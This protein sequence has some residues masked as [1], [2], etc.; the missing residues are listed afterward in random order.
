MVSYIGNDHSSYPYSAVTYIEST[1]P[2]GHTYS[3]TG[4][5]VGENDVL[6][7]SHII[8]SL[9]DGGVAE[10]VDVYPG[11]DRSQAPFGSYDADYVNYF[12]VDQDGDGLMTRSDSEDDLAVLGFD[13]EIVEQTGKFNLDPNGTSD[14]YNITG[15]PAQYADETGPRMTNDYGYIS[16]N[17]YFDV[18]DISE[19][20]VSPGN[21]GSPLWYSSNSDPFVVGVNSTRGWS[22]DIASHYSKIKG[23]MEN[24][25]SLLKSESKG[26]GMIRD[27]IGLY[28]SNSSKFYLQN[29]LTGGKADTTVS[30]GPDNQN[31]KPLSSELGVGLYS[32]DNGTFYLNNDKR[33]GNADQTIGFGPNNNDW[34][35]LADDFNGDN[36]TDLGL[37]SPDRGKFYFDYDQNGGKA[38]DTVGFGPGGENWLPITGDFNGDGKAG[39]GLYN[40]NNGTFYLDN[41]KRG[42]NADHTFG[43]GP[44]GNNW[45]PVAGNWD[46]DE[47]DEI[48]LYNP[49]NA[50]F[51]LDYDNKGGNADKTI[52]FGPDNNNWEPVINQFSED[53]DHPSINVSD[54]TVTEGD[55]GTT[56]AEFTVSL[57]QPAQNEV[58][59]D[60]A[61]SDDTAT[62]GDDYESTSGSL[63]FSPSETEKTV[64][65]DVYGD[66]QV[67]GDETFSLDLSSPT[68]AEL[69]T[70]AATG[71][72][73]DEDTTD[74]N[75]TIDNFAGE[76]DL[77]GFIASPDYNYATESDVDSYHGSLTIEES[78]YYNAYA[79]AHY[80]GE[81]YWVKGEGEINSIDDNY[82][83]AYSYYE[84]KTSLQYKISD[85]NLIFTDLD[86]EY[87]RTYEFE[88]VE[89]YNEDSDFQQ[90]ETLGISNEEVQNE[91][92]L[93]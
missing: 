27:S 23:W 50:K 71:T 87:I 46:N 37:Y 64:N 66:T 45:K 14:E 82:I 36:N 20:K 70:S 30:F 62:A 10:D 73:V 33:G 9:P 6:T 81:K 67:E 18:Y 22:T 21:S 11:L 12:E 29:E 47:Q 44:D 32:Q 55:S 52:N 79:E 31:W 85:E 40:Q 92:D 24:N 39:I 17:S 60:Y 4:V 38:D 56:T 35:P 63:V 42:G 91:A 65:V 75:L 2:N 76:Y 90:L 57:D 89:D 80:D 25:D 59:V 78:G 54:T 34:M 13:Q 93:A 51:Y 1:F 5:V 3:G 49:N 72:I 26:G 15:Y 16:K 69:G 19:L 61:T 28:N 43:F 41:D 86:G 83:Y 68:N 7:A 77:V 88:M 58:T 84:G 53:K 8:Y 48:G 74:Q